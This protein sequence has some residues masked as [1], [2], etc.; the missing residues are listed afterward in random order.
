ME[1]GDEAQLNYLPGVQ[2][3]NK[4]FVSRMQCILSAIESQINEIKST[5]PFKKIGFVTFGS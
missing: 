3:Q 1:P 4:T 5:Y 2:N